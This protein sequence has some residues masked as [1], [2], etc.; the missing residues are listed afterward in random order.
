MQAIVQHSTVGDS[1]SCFV[2][3]QQGYAQHSDCPAEAHVSYVWAQQDMVEHH[4]TRIATAAEGF[5]HLPDL[6]LL[7]IVLEASLFL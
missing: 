1:L 4:L 6:N 3:A 2:N 5:V 7:G